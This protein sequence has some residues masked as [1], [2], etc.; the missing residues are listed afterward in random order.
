MIFFFI[1][2]RLQD[3][4]DRN[5]KLVEI[6]KKKKGGYQAFTDTLLLEKTVNEHYV[7][8]MNNVLKELNSKQKADPHCQ[9][10][11]RAKIKHLD[12]RIEA[13]QQS[14]EKLSY[15]VLG[16]DSSFNQETLNME[17]MV[18]ELECT[19][20]YV[21]SKKLPLHKSC[22]IFKMGFEKEKTNLTENFQKMEN[23][24]QKTVD[25]LNDKIAFLTEEIKMINKNEDTII[26]DL[27]D[28]KVKERL[29]HLNLVEPS[30][31]ETP[32][33][34]FNPEAM[35]T[36][37][38]PDHDPPDERNYPR[39]VPLSTR[40]DYLNSTDGPPSALGFTARSIQLQIINVENL[41]FSDQGSN[42]VMLRQTSLDY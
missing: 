41:Q 40:L 19:R 8:K 22:T 27:V 24:F 25:D 7:K 6:L 18:K 21:N 10:D 13:L 1:L 16:E 3:S 37:G 23:D 20:N 36:L 2:Q 5:P 35:E 29:M 39:V 17:L 31:E 30:S 14:C 32:H 15:L 4:C 42:Y 33:S 38:S 28:E 26:R 9:V 34:S 12:H 11:L